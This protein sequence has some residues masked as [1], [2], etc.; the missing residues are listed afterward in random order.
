MSWI[1]ELDRELSARGVSS[2]Q[3]HLILLEFEDHIACEPGC[4]G[5]LGDP[6]QL[7]AR[8]AEELA[9]EGARR[10][11]LIAIG[12]LAVTALALGISQFP[13]SDSAQS[14]FDNG[15]SL[16]L[17]VPAALGI[18]IAPQVAL[19]AGVLAGLRAVVRRRTAVMPAA[20]IGLLRRRVW[21]A[22]FAG[23]ATAVGIVLFIVNFSAS[24]P[25]RWMALVGGLA[26]LALLALLAT[27]AWLVRSG[28]VATEASGPAGDVA[29]DLRYF[30][31]ARLARRPWL[32]G[33]VVIVVVAVAMTMFEWR[34]EQ[35]LTEGLQRGLFEGLVA[36][37]GFVL[38][39]PAL[40]LIG[41]SKREAT[42]S[43][44]T[45]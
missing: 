39:G 30:G 1:T 28:A 38:L 8:F 33:A 15:R 27:A 40:G 16:A 6:H 37:L 11:A 20:E 17:F 3:R 35:S 7:A 43:P 9:S 13:A 4:E 23:M 22:L 19:V 32:L 14:G 45:S 5:R 29:D 44:E 18:L 12:A 41:T 2:R 10:S 26:G 36:T 34:A 25:A 21:I 31:C 24:L 42:T